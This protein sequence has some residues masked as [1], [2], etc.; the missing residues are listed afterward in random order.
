[1]NSTGGT[2]RKIKSGTFM[3]DAGVV[4]HLDVKDSSREQ[5]KTFKSTKIKEEFEI[6]NVVNNGNKGEKIVTF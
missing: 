6:E 3:T 1:M 5:M 4:K 2:F